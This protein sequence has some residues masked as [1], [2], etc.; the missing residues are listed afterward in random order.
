MVRCLFCA[1][2]ARS[3]GECL[4]RWQRIYSRITWGGK[5]ILLGGVPGVPPAEVVIL[6][7][8]TVGMCATTAF[9]GL[10]AHVTVID[11]DV[12]CCSMS[13]AASQRGHDDFHKA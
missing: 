8:G 4:P 2:S 10:G 12:K 7:G 13:T 3:A 9:H 5:G 6:G 11:K 1:P